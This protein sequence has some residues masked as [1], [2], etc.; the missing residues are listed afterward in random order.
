MLIS[1]PVTCQVYAVALYVE[2]ERAAKELG[3]RK[4]GGFFDDDRQGPA[5]CST[6]RRCT[7]GT[8]SSTTSTSNTSMVVQRVCDDPCHQ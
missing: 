8:G 5:S 1:L 3:V 4:R 2:A 7:C 6:R